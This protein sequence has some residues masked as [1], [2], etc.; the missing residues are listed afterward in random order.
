MPATL[1]KNFAPFGLRVLLNSRPI[2]I[3]LASRTLVVIGPPL[4]LKTWIAI[5]LGVTV[6]FSTCI[7]F[8]LVSLLLK[9][10]RGPLSPPLS[11]LVATE[12]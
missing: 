8:R 5:G 9:H 10:I 6:Y 3:S 2:L 1:E 7:A 11:L 12:N 4:V